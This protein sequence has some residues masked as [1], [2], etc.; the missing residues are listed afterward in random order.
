MAR[1]NAVVS[2]RIARLIGQ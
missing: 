1:K 2:F